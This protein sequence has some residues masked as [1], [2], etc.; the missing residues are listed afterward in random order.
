MNKSKKGWMLGIATLV[1]VVLLLAPWA[2]MYLLGLALVVWLALKRDR[3]LDM[4]SLERAMLEE[5][6]EQ[7][8]DE[9]NQLQRD[10]WERYRDKSRYPDPEQYQRI[11]KRQ[12]RDW[13]EIFSNC[14]FKFA[15]DLLIHTFASGVIPNDLAKLLTSYTNNPCRE[16]AIELIEFDKKEFQKFF[17]N[18]KI[19]LESMMRTRGQN[20]EELSKTL[21]KNEN[22]LCEEPEFIAFCEA[23]LE[24]DPEATIKKEKSA[25]IKKGY[26][27]EMISKAFAEHMKHTADGW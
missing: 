5:D 21:R 14:D 18:N 8:M 4:P 7:L 23:F 1:A 22:L 25:L 27:E 26:S 10:L 19:T 15:E 9:V 20:R 2:I 17:F 13:N 24:D 12:Y 16:T 11:M 3:G 6:E